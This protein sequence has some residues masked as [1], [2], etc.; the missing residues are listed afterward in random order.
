MQYVQL[1]PSNVMEIGRISNQMVSDYHGREI[2]GFSKANLATKLV[3][4]DTRNP[5]GIFR[6][7]YFT[8]RG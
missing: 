8:T 5:L 3:F 7:L 2:D 4:S 1:H 6:S